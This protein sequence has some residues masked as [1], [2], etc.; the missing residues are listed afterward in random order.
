MYACFRVLYVMFASRQYHLKVA[1]PL[2]P[3]VFSTSS[4][5]KKKKMK[6]K[7]KKMISHFGAV[8]ASLPRNEHCLVQLLG[9]AK[10]ETYIT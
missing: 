5:V 6:E 9:K 1:Y 10:K 7:K 8:I 2:P 4:P 3:S